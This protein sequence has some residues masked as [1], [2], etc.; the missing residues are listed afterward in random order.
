MNDEL[1]GV[2]QDF[3]AAEAAYFTAGGPGEADFGELAQHFHPDVVLYQDPGLPYGGDW[4]GRDGMERFLA[5]MS[6]TWERF[7][8]GDQEFWFRGSAAVVLTRVSAR[9]RATGIELEFPIL[10]HILIRDRQLA[11][12]RPFYWN[13]A[14]IAAACSG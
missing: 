8:F 10:Q 7:E 14:A 12:V 6:R 13:T 9:A 4:R 2:L 5:V 11:E 1:R 3:Y